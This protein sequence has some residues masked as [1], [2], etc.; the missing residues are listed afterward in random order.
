MRAKR[1]KKTGECIIYKETQ[2][3]HY[4]RIGNL[5]NPKKNKSL[6]FSISDFSISEME[7]IIGYAAQGRFGDN[8]RPKPSILEP[9]KLWF[10]NAWYKNKGMSVKYAR[11][12]YIGMAEKIAK[13][14]GVNTKN[15]RTPGPKYYE[16]CGFS[17]S[18]QKKKLAAIEKEEEVIVIASQDNMMEDT[19]VPWGSIV[20]LIVFYMCC[21]CCIGSC[22]WCF[23]RRN[24]NEQE[25][26]DELDIEV[27]NIDEYK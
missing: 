14:L 26:N 27:A 17:K 9:Q 15:P 20:F 8:K 21:F 24:K 12:K 19:G 18:Q 22:V 2:W 23:K 7:K 16:G 4:V 10:W 1:N 3:Q 25:I 5:L 13:R 11:E 6:K